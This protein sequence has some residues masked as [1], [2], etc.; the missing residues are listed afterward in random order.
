MLFIAWFRTFTSTSSGYLWKR[1]T[2]QGC[3]FY[4]ILHRRHCTWQGIF[5]Q[6]RGCQMFQTSIFQA[7]K[8][9]WQA[10]SWQTQI[11]SFACS[12]CNLRSKFWNVIKNWTIH[13]YLISYNNIF[14]NI[15]IT[16]Y[17]RWAF[18]WNFMGV[19]F[20]Y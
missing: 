17:C 19:W 12:A 2:Y 20:L 11:S 14:D 10:K 8:F 7:H 3:G 16:F 18:L 5:R 9:L 13:L 6:F 15:M 1:V 4:F